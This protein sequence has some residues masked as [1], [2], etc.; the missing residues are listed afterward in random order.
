VRDGTARCRP[1][2]LAPATC[3]VA[4]R[5]PG[6]LDRL[7]AAPG[8]RMVAPNRLPADAPHPRSTRVIHRV[9]DIG[10]RAGAAVVVG[11]LVLTWLGVGAATGFPPWWETVLYSTSASVSLVMLFAIHHT[12]ARL[13]NVTQRKLDEL[14]RALPGADNR[15]IAAEDAVDA[16]LDALVAGDAAAEPPSG[17]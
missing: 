5:R 17:S 3:C 10:S 13:A 15:Y 11:G 4:G 14:L 12:Q 6:V 1:E 2:D 16:E 9:G 8:L 7:V